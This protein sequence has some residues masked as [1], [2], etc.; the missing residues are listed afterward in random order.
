[1]RPAPVKA[2]A[3]GAQSHFSPF[4]FL[5]SQ[6]CRA[7]KHPRRAVIFGLDRLACNFVHEFTR[8]RLIP[9]MHVGAELLMLFLPVI[10]IAAF[11]NETGAGG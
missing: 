8:R 5:T 9:A 2:A 10:S 1:L 6:L 4:L 11:V 3:P 7:E